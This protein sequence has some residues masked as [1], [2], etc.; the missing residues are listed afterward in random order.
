M[1]R[2]LP[3]ATQ[4]KS[5]KTQVNLTSRPTKKARGDIDSDDDFF[6]GTVLESSGKGKGSAGEAK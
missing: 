4:S 5:S 1:P 2:K 6:S 3:W